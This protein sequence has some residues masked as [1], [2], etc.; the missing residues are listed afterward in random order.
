MCVQFH[1]PEQE[2]AGHSHSPFR[3]PGTVTIMPSVSWCKIMAPIRDERIC[4]ISLHHKISEMAKNLRN[5]FVARV[6]FV[7]ARIYFLMPMHFCSNCAPF[8]HDC[9]QFD[10]TAPFLM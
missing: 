4:P 6:F 10:A 1:A 5:P 7:V 8:C 2:D 3:P 9:A